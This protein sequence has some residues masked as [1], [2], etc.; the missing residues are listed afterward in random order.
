MVTVVTKYG[1]GDGGPGGMK[2]NDRMFRRNPKRS[3]Q[4]VKVLKRDSTG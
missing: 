1:S 4:K 3:S 2:I